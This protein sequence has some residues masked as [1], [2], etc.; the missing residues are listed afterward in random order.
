MYTPVMA[1]RDGHRPLLYAGALVISIFFVTPALGLGLGSVGVPVVPVLLLLLVGVLGVYG[2]AALVADDVRRLLL[3][4]IIV[5]ATARANVPLG[6]TPNG[7]LDVG[8]QLFLVDIPLGIFL[9]IT[10]ASWSR[11]H[12]T[13]PTSL[14]LLFVGWCVVLI[15]V[16][17]GPRPDVMGWYAIHVARYAL[18]ALV[19][20]R[21]IVDDLLTGREA[22]GVIGVAAFG[23]A[24]VATGQI[25]AGPIP[26]LS[27]FGANLQT[28]ASIGSIPTGP[29]VGGFMGGAPF[30]VLLTLLIPV[31]V[32]LGVDYRQLRIPAI[33]ITLW[34]TLLLQ[35][36]A[37]DAVRGAL[38]IAFGVAFV[39]LGW[40]VTGVLW[41][42][43]QDLGR[44]R[45][46]IARS[47]ILTISGGSV[48]GIATVVQ[49]S[50]GTTP[51]R[52]R[53]IPPNV[54]QAWAESTNIPGF[55]TQNLAIRIYQYVSGIDV[56]LQY[57]LTGVGGANFVFV[58]E[59]YGRGITM[60]NLYIGTLS[61]TGVIG[62]ILLFGALWIAARRVW[63]L[64]ANTDDPV[65][66]GLLAGFGGVLAMQIFQPQ[67]LRIVSMMSLWVVLGA[68]IGEVRRRRRTPED[69][70]QSAWAD[71][72]LTMM[73][74]TS[75]VASLGSRFTE[76]TVRIAQT[77]Y[78]YYEESLAATVVRKFY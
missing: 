38:L 56:F 75:T 15:P 43:G 33:V 19:V 76:V 34:W 47:P 26:A 49:L 4:L 51:I 44:L 59:A 30:A 22:L 17:P 9:A 32:G 6:T 41:S 24:I 25:L 11:K 28:V 61:E 39:L 20:V 69:Y 12:F 62:G 18:I 74:S 52:P 78:S 37:W 64:A 2:I 54:G 40:L 70:W 67:Y 7:T 66:I 77:G 10:A 50:T 13:A 21:G 46:T 45:E 53:Y 27:V 29:Y 58:S 16:A 60:H 72:D 1:A 42:R 31:V 71:S 23:H 55:S 65:M 57:P 35:F 48:V 14:L 3:I 73:L 5:L 8:P 68:V 63:W 36:T